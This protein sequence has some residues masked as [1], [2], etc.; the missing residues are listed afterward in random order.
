MQNV[1]PAGFT[2]DSFNNPI[3]IEFLIIEELVNRLFVQIGDRWFLCRDVYVSD[4][5][6]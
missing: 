3:L 4:E 1:I 5:L 2:E 6:S